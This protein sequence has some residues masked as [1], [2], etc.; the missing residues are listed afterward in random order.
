MEVSSQT[1]V[2]LENMDSIV[3]E[4]RSIELLICSSSLLLLHPIFPPYLYYSENDTKDNFMK[5]DISGKRP[6]IQVRSLSL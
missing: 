3:S 5:E 2:I 6:G 1:L 4:D